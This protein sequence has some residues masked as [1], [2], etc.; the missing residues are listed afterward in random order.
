M[1]RAGS[2]LENAH[3]ARRMDT[4]VYEHG[5]TIDCRV[6]HLV[7]TTHTI[8]QRWVDVLGEDLTEETVGA[9]Q[10]LDRK[11]VI[12]H[13]IKW[14]HRLRHLMQHWPARTITKTDVRDSLALPAQAFA[15]FARTGSDVR[16]LCDDLALKHR[17]PRQHRQDQWQAVGDVGVCHIDMHRLR[18]SDDPLCRRVDRS[19]AAKYAGEEPLHLLA[20]PTDTMSRVMAPEET[21]ET[22]HTRSADPI[23]GSK[24]ERRR[25]QLELLR[26]LLHRELRGRYRDS[27]LGSAW[28]LLQPLAMTGVYYF[29]FS[30]LFPNNT[31]PN[32][33]MFILTALLLWNFFA[34]CL[35]LGTAAITGSADIVRKVWFRR[36]LLP[37][38]VVLA[39]AIT[40]TILL[41][42]VIVA[43]VIVSPASLATAVLVPIFFVLLMMLC[44]GI[45]CLLATANV[46]FRDV[47]HLV[48]VILLPLF[49]MTPVFYSLDN[50]PRQPPEWVITLLRYGNPLTPYVES[51][52][53]VALEGAIPGAPLLL[54]C[55]IVGPT[56]ALI[57]V[58]VL[59]RRDDSL[60]VAL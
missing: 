12:R 13:G 44:F 29:L 21:M 36:E 59:R 18:T 40:T 42:V 10:V 26:T 56:M 53:A 9:Q 28:T 14:A 8:A 25:A 49:F 31:I 38:A 11:R 43:D 24:R 33:A 5:V 27:V 41:T 22:T 60:A 54:Y 34:N 15:C 55:A 47:S 2:L 58:W 46:F 1:Q 3:Q 51:I 23:M 16:Q 20:T 57:G 37:M 35:S 19:H 48:S 30:F 17:A 39:Q 6:A 7:D 52:R 32:Y 4:D 45:A 50:F